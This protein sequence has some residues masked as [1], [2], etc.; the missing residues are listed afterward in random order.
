MTKIEFQIVEMFGRVLAFI[1]SNQEKLSKTSMVWLAL[2]TIRSAIAK[3]YEL[4]ALQDNR[5]IRLCT[6]ARQT[7]R[8][9]VKAMIDAIHQ[10]SLAV[11][12]DVPQIEVFFQIPI[13]LRRDGQIIELGEKFAKHA[14][15]LK[16]AF[17]DHHMPENFIEKL[18][19]AIQNLR[20]SIEKQRLAMNSRIWASAKLTETIEEALTNLQRVESIMRNTLHDD[21]ATLAAWEN[22]RHVIKAR[23][24][25]AKPDKDKA[26]PTTPSA[27]EEAAKATSP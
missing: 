2:A 4:A 5:S 7:A 19:E 24:S 11:A 12:I 23:K 25:K 17:V 15:P 9:T 10:T 14:E 3:T 21:P 26:G 18:Q 8:D 13:R 22:A 16:A 20:E 1:E 6:E 27:G